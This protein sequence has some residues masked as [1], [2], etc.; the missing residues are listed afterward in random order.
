MA[1]GAS[2][3]LFVH[4]LDN[5]FSVPLAAAVRQHGVVGVHVVDVYYAQ[6]EGT[7]FKVFLNERYALWLPPDISHVPALYVPDQ[8]PRAPPRVYYGEDICALLKIPVPFLTAPAGQQPP[9]LPGGY[10][11]PYAG[12]GAASF[13]SSRMSDEE[14]SERMRA[15]EAD[16]RA[17]GGLYAQPTARSEVPATTAAAAAS[18]AS[19]AFLQPQPASSSSSPSALPPVG[20]PPPPMGMPALLG[21]GL[22]ARAPLRGLSL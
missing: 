1:S 16:L 8:E 20:G 3:I 21:A 2:S 10:Q 7:L 18:A 6:R 22:G 5:R 15:R 19:P 12:E 14:V 17:S 11:Q 9:Q 13:R 4:S